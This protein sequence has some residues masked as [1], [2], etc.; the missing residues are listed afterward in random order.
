MKNLWLHGIYLSIIGIL[1]FQLWLKTAETR[2]VFSQVDQAL[3]SNN[4]L[5]R[6]NS[7]T[8]LYEIEK[9]YSTNPNKYGFFHTG[10]K[11][12]SLLSQSASNIID[13]YENKAKLQESINLNDLK[14]S[15][16]ILSKKTG[17]VNDEK[18]SLALTKQCNLIKTIQ[19]DTFWKYFMS[20][21][22]TNFQLL[23]NQIKLDE[24]VFLN[25]FLDKVS[26]K[27]EI[28]ELWFH[29]IIAPK[30]GVLIEGEKFQADIFLA[31]YS[32]NPGTG[33]SFT[34]NNQNLPIE[35]GVAYYSKT[36]KTTGLKTIKVNASIRNPATGESTNVKGEFE[37]HIL[38]KCSQNC[39]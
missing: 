29:V 30:K 36:E 25:Y 5:L 23:K 6:L 12:Y 15:L 4:E 24:L 18:E 38:P 7:E 21:P 39:Q 2:F 11:V 16:S 19:N 1:G 10:S 13:K 9:N 3:K 22:S 20:N 17:F 37:Y 34:V 33:L 27:V 35:D 8:I 26:G 31:E 32:I 28:R 14:D